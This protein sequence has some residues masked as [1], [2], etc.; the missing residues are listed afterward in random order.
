MDGAAS[1]MDTHQASIFC[2]GYSDA[3][4]ASELRHLFGK[5]VRVQS[6]FEPAPTPTGLKRHFMIMKVV[7]AEEEVAKCVKKLNNCYWKGGTLCVERSN[8]H[9]D[10][11]I[12]RE[13]R[14]EE[15]DEEKRRVEREE[16]ASKPLPTFDRDHLRLK[17]AIGERGI[18]QHVC[19]STEQLMRKS[20]QQAYVL[21][22]ENKAAVLSCGRRL[23]FEYHDDGSMTEK[24][25][26]KWGNDVDQEEGEDEGEGDATV[27]E[28]TTAES[29][30][31]DEPPAAAPAPAPAAGAGVRKGFGTLLPQLKVTKASTKESAAEFQ[32]V[33]DDADSHFAGK[34]AGGLTG[35]DM[36]DLIQEN[37]FNEEDML[38]IVRDENL[39]EEHVPSATAEEL[40]DNELAGARNKAMQMAMALLDQGGAP[41]EDGDAP[42][43]GAT[44]PKKD[45]AYKSGWDSTTIGHFDPS[46]EASAA[47]YL[48]DDAE[49][50]ETIRLA[51]VHREEKEAARREKDRER[52]IYHDEDQGNGAGGGAE[53]EASEADLLKLKNI[54]SKDDGGVWF[55]D[56]GT[57][58]KT[59]AS[60][61]DATA[62]KI[63]LE[64]EKF[65]FDVR[66]G[67]AGAEK[68]GMTFGFFDQSEGA[69]AGET[70]TSSSS[71]SS[72]Q[73]S[74]RPAGLGSP[75]SSS[76]AAAVTLP[77]Q[78]GPEVGMGHSVSLSPSGDS[79]APAS[80]PKIF[81]LLD[82]L[83]QAKRFRRDDQ[84]SEE[85][86][87]K[88]WQDSREKH[89]ADY[90]RR[91]KDAK[92]RTDRYNIQNHRFKAHSSPA[93]HG[94]SHGSGGRGKQVRGG[95]K[96]RKGAK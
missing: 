41:G 56:T 20:N 29:L 51:R 49:T 57:D 64:A 61:G 55:G 81:S 36:N 11:R 19:V 69:A 89:S 88:E 40:Q 66:D 43:A 60:K 50:E 38:E 18:G 65:G 6:V 86:L 35:R 10:K 33:M 9:Y 46:N 47:Q 4:S 68:G 76:S 22:G 79:A 82:V 42:A 80:T 74:E 23:V 2:S 32:R 87:V 67:A 62:D 3:T 59:E 91:R 58:L 17:K 95:K 48:M 75:S 15:D 70:T 63:F 25:V 94:H 5:M 26:D 52:G 90:R 84:A 31:M 8:E 54:F 14:E 93:G 77:D 28:S 45:R 12:E 30:R 96:H 34:R 1:A 13:H 73:A 37:E 71:S 83:H 78:M 7:A 53:P 44:A 39:E 85:Q 24:E 92:R 21:R 27:L 72:A 16:K